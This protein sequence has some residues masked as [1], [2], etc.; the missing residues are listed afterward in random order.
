VEIRWGAN[1]L[2]QPSQAIVGKGFVG[3]VREPP[4][5]NSTN[6]KSRHTCNCWRLSWGTCRLPGCWWQPPGSAIANDCGKRSR[7]GGSRTALIRGPTRSRERGRLA[8]RPYGIPQTPNRATP[9]IA[10]GS[11]G[12]RVGCRDAGGNRPGQQSQAIPGKGSVGAVREPPSSAAPRDR[13]AG[14]FANRP[15]NARRGGGRIL[16]MA[17][18]RLSKR[19]LISP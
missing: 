9:V 17:E 1:H 8:N 16:E 15:Y 14:R 19:T 12:A 7:R 4:L 6:P 5:R 3:A 10:G 2:H 11:H 18:G 13:A